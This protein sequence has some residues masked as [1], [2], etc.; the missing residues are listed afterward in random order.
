MRYTIIFV[1]ENYIY[2]Y[3]K[4]SQITLLGYT[5]PKNSY[6]MTFMDVDNHIKETPKMGSN[7]IAIYK[8]INWIFFHKSQHMKNARDLWT[9]VLFK[10]LIMMKKNGC[11]ILEL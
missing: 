3:I 9:Q 2:W 7:K 10:N 5:K 1:G 6:K 8:I 11:A 4:I